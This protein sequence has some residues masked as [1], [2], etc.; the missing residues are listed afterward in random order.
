MPGKNGYEVAKYVKQSPRLSHIP[1]VL[2]TGAFEPVDQARAAEVGCDGVLAKPFEP[3]LVIGRVKELLSE[4]PAA[5]PPAATVATATPEPGVAP[6][7]ADLDDYFDRLDVAFSKLSAGSARQGADKR[8]GETPAGNVPASDN[9]EPPSSVADEIDRYVSE[10]SVDHP[11]DLSLVPAPQVA[12]LSEPPPPAPV[13]VASTDKALTT[14]SAQKADKAEKT[15]EAERVKAVESDAPV[16]KEFPSAPAAIAAVPAQAVS[17]PVETIAAPAA[18]TSAPTSAVPSIANAFAAIL[19]AEQGEA[20]SPG[21][22][23]WPVLPVQS[24]PEPSRASLELTDEEVD[25]IVGRVLDRMSDRVVRETV[26]TIAS[27]TAERLV[28][29]EIERIKSAIK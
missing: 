20:P 1:V 5:P 6:A 17:R 2:L 10:H 29:D 11:A 13:E 18:S 25:R 14:D 4:A 7:P 15:D 28:R 19:A 24:V 8:E 27:D 16:V 9:A 12:H 26:T 21:R 3:Q 23:G 22:P